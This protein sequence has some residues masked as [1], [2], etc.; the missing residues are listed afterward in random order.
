MNKVSPVFLVSLLLAVCS[1]YLPAGAD[2]R[3]KRHCGYM[4]LGPQTPRIVSYGASCPTALRVARAWRDATGCTAPAGQNTCTA[5]CS[6]AC[7]VLGDWRCLAPMP[8]R[9]YDACYRSRSEVKIIESDSIP[10]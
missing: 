3:T 5:P 7:T 9:G 6:R 10:S 2:A 1:L 4:T 8:I